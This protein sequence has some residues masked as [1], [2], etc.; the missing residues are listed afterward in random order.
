MRLSVL[1]RYI[2]KQCFIMGGKIERA[3]FCFYFDRKKLKNPQQVLTQSFESL[4][5]KGLLRGYGRR[6]PQK[7]FIESVSLTPD[8][9]KAAWKVIEDQQM[10]L[11]K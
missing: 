6:T 11:L 2:L 4:I 7:W 5:D 10:K 9:K 1:Q 8:G 3:L